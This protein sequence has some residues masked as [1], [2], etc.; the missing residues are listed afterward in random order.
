MELIAETELKT[1]IGI[2]N[3]K[4]FSDGKTNAYV[5]VK[6]NVENKE[7]VLCRI[8]SH[9]VAAHYF[10]GI[11]CDCSKQMLFS[12]KLINDEKLGIIIWLE[13]QEGRGN[14]HYAKILAEKFK[15]KGLNQ[16]D[17]Y[18]KA[19]YPS[20]NRQYYQVKKIIDILK[21]KSV[22]LISKSQKKKKLLEEL[23]VKINSMIDINQC[24]TNPT[25]K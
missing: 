7:N 3:E 23:G 9:C 25:N 17:A 2:F 20:D 14:G 22:V 6:G 4:M 19:G 10:Y 11:E 18:N 8:H 21:I 15:K 16:S 24:L 13:D 1:M 5:L 12:Q